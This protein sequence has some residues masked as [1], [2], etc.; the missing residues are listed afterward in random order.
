MIEFFKQERKLDH[1]KAVRDSKE[2]WD[3]DGF[4]VLT[5]YGSIPNKSK[6]YDPDWEKNGHM[7]RAV[8]LYARYAKEQKPH[9][10][11]K[12][13]GVSIEIKRRPGGSPLILITAPGD[14]PGNTL[15]YGHL[16]KQPEGGTWSEGLE[17]WKA[18]MKDGNLYGRGMADDGY[19][20]PM[21]LAS[22]R[23]LDREGVKRPSCTI[24]IE[25][26]EESGSSDMSY[27]LDTYAKEIGTPDTVICL[28][29][30]AG[31]YRRLW[32]T[33][34][35]RGNVT[36]I[37]EIESTGG[38]SGHVSGE[39][40][41][42]ERASRILLSRIEDVE[43]GEIKL[44]SVQVEIPQERKEQIEKASAVVSKTDHE[45]IGLCSENTVELEVRKTWKAMLTV[46]GLDGLPPVEG[47][48]NIQHPKHVQEQYAAF[49]FG[50]VL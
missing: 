8:Q 49:L 43:T 9:L 37:L 33:T 27:Y 31:D 30:G 42:A 4:P 10:R 6:D 38:H 21:A 3:K 18:V 1:E 23:I 13:K 22:L 25:S 35:L 2:I 45:A 41:S 24:V 36:G 16:D 12:G 11:E 19:A 50:F 17:P 40:I 39:Y 26:G 20:L 46:I 7:E 15:I 29:S 44:P 5:E 34:S 14:L 47:A 28:D 48:G 32:E